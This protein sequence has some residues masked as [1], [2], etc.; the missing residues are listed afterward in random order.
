MEVSERDQNLAIN[1]GRNGPGAHLESSCRWVQTSFI[2]LNQRSLP[3]ATVKP[4]LKQ[5][6]LQR[7][8]AKA[9]PVFSIFFPILCAV[10]S[11][12][13]IR[14][15]L[16]TVQGTLQ[17]SSGGVTG[18]LRSWGGGVRGSNTHF[19]IRKNNVRGYPYLENWQQ[20][21]NNNNKD[22]RREK[23]KSLSDLFP[24]LAR[25][26]GLHAMYKKQSKQTNTPGEKKISCVH[27]WLQLKPQ[28][29]FGKRKIKLILD[30]QKVQHTVRKHW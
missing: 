6:R 30:L 12:V 1:T 18:P 11:V 3:L 23:Q 21:N 19:W 16:P 15:P 9:T 28:D 22:W 10:T 8:T 29:S 24:G 25:H 14:P 2:P 13:E 26:H 27:H 17:Q 20:N 7:C 4:T 5:R